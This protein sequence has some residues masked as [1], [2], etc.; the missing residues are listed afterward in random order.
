MEP[1]MSLEGFK[2]LEDAQRS[3]DLL[4]Q[5]YQEQGYT[6]AQTKQAPHN[7]HDKFQHEQDEK[8][9]AR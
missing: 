9:A 8:K 5:F 2:I 6:I 1:L 4:N 7:I 3:R